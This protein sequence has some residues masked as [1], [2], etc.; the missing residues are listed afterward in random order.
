MANK[1]IQ[2]SNWGERTSIS[3]DDVLFE[4]FY[5][6]VGNSPEDKI[7]DIALSKWGKSRKAPKGLSKSVQHEI[8][9]MIAKPS[10]VK[11]VFKTDEYSQD[12]MEL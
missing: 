6:S 3:M 5:A 8:L 10:L 11:K 12:E 9:R 1:V 4:L 7:R 2:V